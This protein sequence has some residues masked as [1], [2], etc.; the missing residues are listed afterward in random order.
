M[1]YRDPSGYEYSKLSEGRDG[2]CSEGTEH[3]VRAHNQHTVRAEHTVRAQ[4]R[5]H[6]KYQILIP[7]R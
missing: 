7:R 6:S 3:T 2:L 4:S 1:T 5:A